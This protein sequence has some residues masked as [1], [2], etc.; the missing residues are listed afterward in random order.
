MYLPSL[1]FCLLAASRI[2][3]QCAVTAEVKAVPIKRDNKLCDKATL[4]GNRN[5]RVVQQKVF[6]QVRELFFK[7]ISTGW[8]FRE[9]SKHALDAFGAR[10][11]DISGFG[12][13]LDNNLKHHL[14]NHRK[15]ALP[16]QPITSDWKRP[17][18]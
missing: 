16:H 1:L 13:F 18:F 7:W 4:G 15:R 8:N 17:V 6:V 2:K 9:R 14:I 10:S 12:C 11:W 3:P 5:T